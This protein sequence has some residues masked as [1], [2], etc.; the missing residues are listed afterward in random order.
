MSDPRNAP[1]LMSDY[2][3]LEVLDMVTSSS[4]RIAPFGNNACRDALDDAHDV[5]ITIADETRPDR[6]GCRDWR[7]VCYRELFRQ[8]GHGISPFDGPC[9]HVIDEVGSDAFAA[10]LAVAG[11]RLHDL[12]SK[13]EMDFVG[14]NTFHQVE[15]DWT[16]SI[17]VYTEASAEEGEAAG[18]VFLPERCALWQFVDDANEWAEDATLDAECDPR[19]TTI[20]EFVDELDMALEYLT[21]DEGGPWWARTVEKQELLLLTGGRKLPLLRG[22]VDREVDEGSETRRDYLRRTEI[23]SIRVTVSIIRDSL[24]LLDKSNGPVE[25]FSWYKENFDDLV[26]DVERSTDHYYKNHRDN[27]ADAKGAKESP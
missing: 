24:R 1:L 6:A 9:D 10:A 3:D 21:R 23:I 27:S 18:V 26:R 12:G 2:D 7:L 14:L 15:C 19:T 5:F 20:A 17:E 16:A 13:V 25:M 4:V 11:P 22:E 8:V